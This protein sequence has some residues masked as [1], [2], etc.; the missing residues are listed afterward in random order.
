MSEEKEWLLL[1]LPADLDVK[2][3]SQ[4]ET[5]PKLHIHKMH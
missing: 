3:V 4:C 5:E 1:I 2:A